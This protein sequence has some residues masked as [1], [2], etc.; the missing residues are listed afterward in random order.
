MTDQDA[1]IAALE[2]QVKT[3]R[4]IMCKLIDLIIELRK[5]Q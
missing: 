1:R 3:A 5:S 4:K 2:L